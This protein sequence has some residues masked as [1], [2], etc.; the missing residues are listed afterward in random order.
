MGRAE[1]TTYWNAHALGSS[2][3]FFGKVFSGALR[4]GA[5][6]RFVE[7]QEGS[8]EVRRSECPNGAPHV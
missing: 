6:C 4:G 8:G 5:R 2:V 7:A 3:C 1:T